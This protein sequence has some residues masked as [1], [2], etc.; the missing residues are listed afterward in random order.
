MLPGNEPP[1]ALESVHRIRTVHSLFGPFE[2]RRNY[3]YN[4]KSS[5]G[6]FLL[7]EALGLEGAC[8][9]E[10]PEPDQPP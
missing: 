10:H 2:L 4:A 1:A 3:L 5:V 8:T 9:L 7:D 6:H